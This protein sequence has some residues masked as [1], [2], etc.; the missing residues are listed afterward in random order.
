MK[1]YKDELTGI[2]MFDYEGNFIIDYTWQDLQ[3]ICANLLW[4]SYNSD[5][6]GPCFSIPSYC[7][8]WKCH[9][10][11]VLWFLLC[12]DA[13]G[14]DMFWEWE[15]DFESDE[16]SRPGISD[17]TTLYCFCKLNKEVVQLCPQSRAGLES[18]EDRF[19]TEGFSSKS[20]QILLTFF[21]KYYLTEDS[22]CLVWRKAGSEYLSSFSILISSLKT[23]HTFI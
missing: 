8:T 5:G 12:S 16:Y 2:R 7:M 15:F 1:L 11:V 10:A 14:I 4:V 9:C 6:L 19:A 3:L 22:S 21:Q 13:I 20:G 23:C 18:P 17:L